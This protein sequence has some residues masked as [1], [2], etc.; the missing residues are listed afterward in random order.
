MKGRAMV[1]IEEN[2][3]GDMEVVIE[4]PYI[5]HK[6][7]KILLGSWELL[8]KRLGCQGGE[9]RSLKAILIHEN[10]IYNYML[11]KNMKLTYL[12]SGESDF[13]G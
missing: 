11:A 2:I 1:L 6:P 13:G 5:S 8:G 7:N 12:V 3:A 10:P 9:P 4:T